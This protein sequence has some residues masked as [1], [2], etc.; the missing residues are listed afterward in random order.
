MDQDEILWQTPSRI[1][2]C[3]TKEFNR[4]VSNTKPLQNW[5][6]PMLNQPNQGKTHLLSPRPPPIF[7]YIINEENRT[8]WIVVSNLHH[9]TTT[10][11]ITSAFNEYGHEIRNVS[12]LPNPHIKQPRN[13]FYI[14][15]TPATNNKDIYRVDKCQNSII[16]IEPPNVRKRIVHCARFQHYNH[17]KR[18]CNHLYIP[19]A[20][21]TNSKTVL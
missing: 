4:L 17:T 20:R 19:A 9:A 14:D 13:M 7:A 12:N 15:L 8:F 5:F 6:N 2:K 16:R 18:C 1:K 21:I 3:K 11:E 10:K